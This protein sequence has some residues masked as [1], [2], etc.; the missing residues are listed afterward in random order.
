MYSFKFTIFGNIYGFMRKT[1]PIFA[2]CAACLILSQPLRADHI[3]DSLLRSLTSVS[4]QEKIVLLNTLA[5]DYSFS[6]P[7]QAH[8]FVDLAFQISEKTGDSTGLALSLKNKG[9][10]YYFTGN[11]NQ[12]IDCFYKAGQLFSL[13]GN[14]SGLSGCLNNTAN[15]YKDQ[16]KYDLALRYYYRSYAC[17]VR[18]NDTAGIAV[19]W[20]NIGQVYQLQA[21]YGRA[22][23]Y[24]KKSLA[25]E[26]LTGNTE[27]AGECYINL[28]AAFEEN[29]NYQEALS[30][31]HKALGIFQQ[32]LNIHRLALTY[33][34]IAVLYYDS[35][36]PEKSAQYA[37]L[38]LQ[39]RREINDWPG[40]AS[41]SALLAKIYYNAGQKE[42]ADEYFFTAIMTDFECGNLKKVAEDL[43]TKA[44]MLF[45]DG[46]LEESLTYYLNSYEIARDINARSVNLENYNQLSEIY[47]LLKDTGQA[48]RFS[49]MY[50]SLKDSLDAE[51]LSLNPSIPD[52]GH[53]GEEVLPYE[54]D[55]EKTGFYAYLY[56]LLLVL[57]S[58]AV[59]ILLAELCYM[60]KKLKK[61]KQINNQLK[62][63]RNY[64]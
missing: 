13:A 22:I 59:L 7:I 64:V 62:N 16:G 32:S 39:K 21:Y 38:A 2:L 34:N 31:Y 19:C 9:I 1:L 5:R 60:R 51:S 50:I 54:K 44:K 4:D 11:Y 33:H 61:I 58:A 42:K 26:L 8:Y 40:I 10:I 55:K 46:L 41:T 36:K 3:S 56:P 27:G 52:K 35:D 49:R 53:A 43:Q 47:F 15:I 37:H 48:Y 28:G 18:L 25:L 23:E 29:G 17:D 12:S 63:R 45:D 6:D 20:S 30:Y 24:Y 57:L 14:L